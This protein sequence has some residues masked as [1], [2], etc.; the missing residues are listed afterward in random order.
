MIYLTKFNLHRLLFECLSVSKKIKQD[1]TKEKIDI[2]NQEILALEIKTQYLTQFHRSKILLCEILRDENNINLINELE[3][4][5]IGVNK[6]RQDD[7]WVREVATPAY[8]HNKECLKLNS[9][10]L[11]ILIPKQLSAEKKMDYRDFF[12]KHYSAYGR[13]QNKKDPRILAR[14]MIEH[15]GAKD[16]FTQEELE[17][18][19]GDKL[20]D[21]W[22]TE[23]FNDKQ[24]KN[25]GHD[26]FSLIN[27]RML[28]DEFN[29]LIE[30]EQAEDVQKAYIFKQDKSKWDISI[31]DF[32][33][34]TTPTFSR[35]LSDADREK[36]KRIAE[37]QN[38]ITNGI[39]HLYL[40]DMEKMGIVAEE[41]FLKKA[42][43]KSCS[44]SIIAK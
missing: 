30:N 24:I 23:Y 11:N 19:K 28:R 13:T 10:F 27:L 14:L 20:L 3:I 9:D 29:Q 33:P 4:T 39:I 36:Y 7:R 34:I 22:I 15:Y 40:L 35:K 1:L 8:H 38:K 26:G 16:I 42:G 18:Y 21:Y 5:A 25:S 12:Q 41:D 31:R 6:I 32:N 17:L 43:F 37:L 2:S 44:C